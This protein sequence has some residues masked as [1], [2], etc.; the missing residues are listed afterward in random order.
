VSLARLKSGSAFSLALLIALML[1]AA[2]CGG[3][4]EEGGTITV[5]G[6]QTNDHGSQD[7]SGRASSTWSSTTSISSP[8]S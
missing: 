1:V 8:R 7:V 4:E 6:E 3:N 5:G 2:A